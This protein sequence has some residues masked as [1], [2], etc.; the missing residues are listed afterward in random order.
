MT[1]TGK[2]TRYQKQSNKK[3]NKKKEFAREIQKP[4][5]LKEE[6]KSMI[7]SKIYQAYDDIQTK[8]L[9]TVAKPPRKQIKVDVASIKNSG[10]QS[11]ATTYC[12]INSSQMSQSPFLKHNNSSDPDSPQKI[13]LCTNDNNISSSNILVDFEQGNE[14]T[15]RE[16]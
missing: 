11:S 10:L 9:P 4:E 7:I 12:G 2:G 14:D 6:E 15:F 1:N 13:V 5:S 8:E 3:I 16:I